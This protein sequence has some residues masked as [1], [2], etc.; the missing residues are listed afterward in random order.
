MNTYL[1]IVIQ[2]KSGSD[3]NYYWGYANAVIDDLKLIVK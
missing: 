1:T 3:D 2:L